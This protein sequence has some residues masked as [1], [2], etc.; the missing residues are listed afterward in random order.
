MQ[1]FITSLRL[2]VLSTVPRSFPDISKTMRSTKSHSELVEGKVSQH[3]CESSHGDPQG[4]GYLN[5]Q[6]PLPLSLQKQTCGTHV[7]T[8]LCCLPVSWQ[9]W[10]YSK[11]LGS[12]WE[13]SPLPLFSASLTLLSHLLFTFLC[14]GSHQPAVALASLNNSLSQTHTP[15]EPA[16]TALHPVSCVCCCPLLAFIASSLSLLQRR[17]AP[18][19]SN[20]ISTLSSPVLVHADPLGEAHMAWP[21]ATVLPEPSCF[22]FLKSFPACGASFHP[23]ASALMFSG[24]ICSQELMLG[25]ASCYVFIQPYFL[26][27]DALAMSSSLANVGKKWDLAIPSSKGLPT[28][29]LLC[30]H[31]PS[32]VDQILRIQGKTLKV[33]DG[34]E[35]WKAEL[36]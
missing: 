35:R 18:C 10:L 16:L 29:D 8:S 2:L 31:L 19:F 5:L 4:D 13:F 22:L 34:E 20:A 1:Y 14:S 27:S 28:C 11:N 7:P 36:P 9:S 26:C 32:F 33:E 12:G 6:T 3:M 30:S 23:R 17:F 25:L 15:Q 24:H 21:W